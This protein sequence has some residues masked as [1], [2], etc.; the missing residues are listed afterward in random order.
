MRPARI[1][2]LFLIFFFVIIEISHCI[3][4]SSETQKL[5]GL[6]IADKSTGFL[7]KLVNWMRL[8]VSP[9]EITESE[10]SNITFEVNV[11]ELLLQWG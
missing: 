5:H 9:A 7:S 6:D 4:M 8:E 10:Y 3:S 2:S 11:E 1:A